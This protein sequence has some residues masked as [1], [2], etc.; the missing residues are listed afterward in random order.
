MKSEGQ[1]QQPTEYEPSPAQASRIKWGRIISLAGALG[2]CVSSFFPHYGLR[3]MVSVPLFFSIDKVVAIAPIMCITEVGMS[4]LVVGTPF[5]VAVLL[6]PLLAFRAVPRV[7][8]TKGAGKFL[9]WSQCAI[10]LFVLIA[11][12]GAIVYSIACRTTGDSLPRLFALSAVG[13]VG[14]AL[15]LVAMARCCLPRKAAAVQF[16]LWAFYTGYFASWIIFEIFVTIYP[17]LWLSIAACGALV[18]GSAID[19]FQCRPVKET[20]R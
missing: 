18:I 12:T 15:A 3:L 10:C 19:W 13:I 20:L 11:S 8:A 4:L 7:D 5:I 14:L 17:G 2:L 16:S 1:P 9:A 6:M